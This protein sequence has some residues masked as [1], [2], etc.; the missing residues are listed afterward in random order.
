MPFLGRPSPP[1]SAQLRKLCILRTIKSHLLGLVGSARIH[2]RFGCHQGSLQRVSR[3][4]E[5]ASGTQQKTA[6]VYHIEVTHAYQFE[7]RHVFGF[8][9][10]RQ[11]RSWAGIVEWG[12]KSGPSLA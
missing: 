9:D 12:C 2:P 8:S 5:T 6:D 4:V 1:Q 3:G 10:V 7:F 11:R